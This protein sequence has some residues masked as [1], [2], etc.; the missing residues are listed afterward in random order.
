MMESY[1]H[2]SYGQISI[3]RVQGRRKFYG[4]ELE[5][6]H[7]IELQISN[8]CMERDLTHENYYS[9]RRPIVSVRMTAVQFSELITSMNTDG[10]PC[11]LEIVNG[12]KVEPLPTIES[13]KELVHRKF[14]DRMVSFANSIKDLQLKAKSLVKKKSLSKQDMQDLIFAIDHISDE[15]KD[16]I[17]YFIECFQETTDHIVVDA[18]NE[19]E[20]A[21]QHKINVLGLQ[22]LHQQNKLLENE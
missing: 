21:I 18:K 5:H 20:S 14:K 3:A 15:T 2:P 8:S 1:R 6:D 9:E 4:S 12:E 17:P 11:T 19:I 13:H 22:A 16:N 7:F 10:V